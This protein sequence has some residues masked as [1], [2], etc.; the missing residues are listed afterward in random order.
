MPSGASLSHMVASRARFV[1][2][3]VVCLAVLAAGTGLA[4]HGVDAL[5][6]PAF[7]GR[8]RKPPAPERG[9]EVVGSI[10][11]AGDVV[12]RQEFDAEQDW[13]AGLRVRTV[14]WGAEPDAYD[15]TWSLV[16][17]AADGRGRRTVRSGTIATAAATDW[18][19]VDLRFEP[20]PDSFATRYAFRITTGS[21][22]PAQP[23]G[24]PLFRSGEDQ[25]ACSARRRRGAPPAIPNPAS[26][27]VRPVHAAEGA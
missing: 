10:A 2:A 8:P 21:G 27:D 17:V 13:L 12:V 23:L 26:L 18:G 4:F 1:V 19:Y 5:V 15:C 16:E 22:S 25:P 14:T 24:V 6:R 9:S 11:I 20:I 7:E 3:W